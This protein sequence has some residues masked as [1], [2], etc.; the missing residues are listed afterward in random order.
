MEEN[1]QIRIPLR[2]DYRNGDLLRG[3]DVNKIT[4]RVNELTGDIDKIDIDLSGKLDT[5]AYTEDKAAIESRIDGKQDTLTAGSGITIENNVISAQKPDLSE[6]AT[7]GYVDTHIAQHTLSGGN[8]VD[9][10]NNV[11]TAKGYMHSDKWGIFLPSSPD[12]WQLPTNT[13]GEH[14]QVFLGRGNYNEIDGFAQV[15]F[16]NKNKAKNL[17]TAYSF[18]YGDGNTLYDDAFIYGSRN[19]T[20]GNH[21]VFLGDGNEAARNMSTHIGYG[22]RTLNE[23]EIAIGNFNVSHRGDDIGDT[24]G[25]SED[26]FFTIGRGSNVTDDRRNLLEIMEDGTF[27]IFGVGNYAGTEIKEQ[28]PLVESLQGVILRI[29]TGLAGKQDQ[30]TAGSGI[31]IINGVISAQQ[32]DLSPYAL[33]ADVATELATKVDSG[34]YV[35]DKAAIQA[36]IDGKVTTTAFTAYTASTNNTLQGHGGRLDGHDTRIG[37]LE[38]NKQDKL[39]AGTGIK[40]ENNVISMQ[41]SPAQIDDT[42]TGTTTTWSSQKI[43]EVVETKVAAAV[44]EMRITLTNLLPTGNVLAF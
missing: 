25:R 33:S 27:Y 17:Y 24:S 15:I 39:S 30:L 26:T 44:D 8:N 40:I 31:T 34:A 19:L 22:L 28:N 14:G 37:N 5:S 3:R 4:H 29:E 43:N 23:R 12:D 13:F 21:V 10:T 36:S 20:Y 7:T 41:G 9:I 18:I 1:K 32:P 16:G 38:T 2:E 6:Y 42:A 11:V 35:Q